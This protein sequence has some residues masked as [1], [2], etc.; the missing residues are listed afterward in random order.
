[1]GIDIKADKTSVVK[2]SAKGTV[3]SIKNDPRYGL[4]IIIEHQDGYQTLYSNLLSSEFVQVGE[5]V[6]QGQSIG[7]VG[8][9]APFE[10][11]DSPH[12][13]FEI[14]KDGQTLDPLQVIK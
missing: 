11:V 8:D 12:L 5:Q 2:A 1:M 4:S 7:T 13:H 3:K 6:E 14:S 10:I 9:T